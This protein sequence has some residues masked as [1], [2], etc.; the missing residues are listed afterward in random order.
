MKSV[1]DAVV[2]ITGGGSGIGRLMALDFASRGAKVVIWDLNDQ[3]IKLVEDE[4][5]QKGVT[6]RGMLCDVSRREDVYRQAENIVKEL[7]PVDILINNAGVVSGK[8]MLETPDDRIEKTMQ[9]NVLAL[10]WTAKAFLPRMIERNTG[11]IVTIS[12][13]AGLIGVR[14]LADYCASKFAA[15]GFDESIRMELR[16]SKSKVRTTVVCPFFI[17]TGMFSGV[18]TRFPFLLPILKSSYAA[19][20]IVLAILKNKRRLVMPRFVSTLFLLRLFPI[21]WVDA[22]ADFVGISHSMDEFKGRG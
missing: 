11:H 21:P 6:V 18:K 3:S 22:I 5:A 20:K 4:A 16:R 12:S 9:V 19:R 13:A 14:G 10:F 8:P 7:G 17:D 1:K 2:L 15:Y